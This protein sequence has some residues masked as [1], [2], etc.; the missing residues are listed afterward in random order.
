MNSARNLIA[1]FAVAMSMSVAAPLAADPLDDM[2]A[3]PRLGDYADEPSLLRPLAQQ[4]NAKAQYELGEMYDSGLGV[5]QDFAEAVKWYRRAADQ[6][7]ADAQGALARMYSNGWG[8]PNDYLLA[9]MW[10]NL[11]ASHSP[12]EGALLDSIA[13]EMTPAQIEEAQA[14]AHEWQPVSATTTDAK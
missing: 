3:A 14:R 5:P 2:H 7:Y 8:V 1:G 12:K 10:A 11:A 4:G 13:A 6:D 9:L